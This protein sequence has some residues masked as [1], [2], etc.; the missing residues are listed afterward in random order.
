MYILQKSDGS[1]VVC[2][3]GTQLS[4]V[5]LVDDNINWLLI[6]QVE[7]SQEIWALNNGQYDTV[8]E[9]MSFYADC[10]EGHLVTGWTLVEVVT[11]ERRI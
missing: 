9:I 5:T 7:D 1:Q 10:N 6:V 4:D 2:H 8:C 11:T 3:V